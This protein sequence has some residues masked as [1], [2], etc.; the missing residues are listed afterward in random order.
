MSKDWK[1][2]SC[3]GSEDERKFISVSVGMWSIY[4]HT[5]THTK[6][7][8][9]QGDYELQSQSKTGQRTVRTKHH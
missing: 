9:R 8:K 3:I 1:G 4:T 6:E 2:E 7:N 5:H